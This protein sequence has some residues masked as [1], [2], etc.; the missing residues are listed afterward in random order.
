MTTNDLQPGPELDAQVGKALGLD[1]LGIMK[2]NPNYEEAGCYYMPPH[3]L[4]V[5]PCAVERPVYL[6]NC[7][8]ETDST[9]D[10]RPY[11]G[12]CYH[13][14]EVVSDYSTNRAAAGLIVDHLIARGMLQLETDGDGVRIRFVPRGG[15]RPGLCEAVMHGPTMQ[16]A[17]C[18][19][20]VMLDRNAKD[21]RSE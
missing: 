19:L 6:L 17:L 4:C 12:H 1:V 21:E 5:S 16:L 14:L 10:N 8:C 9:P 11:F 18:R 15:F 3:P 2:V 13:C 20:L 7:Y